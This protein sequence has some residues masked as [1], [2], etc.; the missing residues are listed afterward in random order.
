[1]TSLWIIHD[2]KA[3][4]HTKLIQVPETHKL[5]RVLKLLIGSIQSLFL[6]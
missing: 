2:C 3:T 4:P 5:I 1:M 6:L